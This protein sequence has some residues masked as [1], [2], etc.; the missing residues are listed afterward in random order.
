MAHL[1]VD[2]ENPNLQLSA[3]EGQSFTKTRKLKKGN[4][5]KHDKTKLLIIQAR[6]FDS[7]YLETT[8]RTKV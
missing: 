6:F 2:T 4:V 1:Q 5:P 3:A 7:K 8:L